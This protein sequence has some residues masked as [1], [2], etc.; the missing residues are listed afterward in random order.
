MNQRIVVLDGYALNPGDLTWDAFLE[1][2]ELQVFDR[3]A[4]DEILSRSQGATAIL[5]NKTPLR[6]DT[7]NQLPDLRYIGVLATGYD[8]IDS[9]AAREKSIAVTN[10]PTYGTDSVAQFAFALIL[11][12]CHRVQ[13]HA[14]DVSSGG[15]AKNPDWS[16]HLAPL[17]EL[18]GKTI[19]IVGYGRIGRQ[20]AAIA[21]AFGMN[22]LAHDPLAPAGPDMV[23]LE[24]LLRNS[25]VV[26]LHCPLTPENR[27][28]I[29]ADRLR[30]M[31]PAAF[32]INTARG[33]LVVEQD[34]ADAL[35]AGKLGGAG[36]DVLP[37]EPPTNG[38]PLMN[39]KNCIVTPH[40]AWA[41]KE[42]RA[43][44]MQTAVD[45]LRAFLA[46]NPQN[47]VNR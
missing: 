32:L 25:D 27:G 6:A 13:R 22:V 11:E 37:A 14:D 16:Y 24:E 26:S 29:N 3:T 34:L 10:I 30:M 39:A 46:G 42:A 23:S 38:S 43:R 35:S 33:P 7:L 41:T 28:L 20:A 36:L 45:N 2:G 19:G 44:L 4:A 18:A 5:M 17:I 8:V 31:K 9:S 47:V 15:W 1:L 12:L 21:R 40:I